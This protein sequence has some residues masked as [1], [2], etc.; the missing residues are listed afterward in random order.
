M[1]DYDVI[2]VG[3]G[4]AGLTAG[5]HLSRAG[6]RTLLLERELL[7]G[8]LKNVHRVDEGGPSGAQLASELAEAVA[9][10]GLRVEEAEATGIE[11]FSSTRWVAC[12]DGR[13]YS[14]AVVVVAAGSRCRRLGVPGEELLLGRGVIDCTPCD[15]G[16]F[17]DRA[18]A[19]CGSDD[20]ALA[21]ALYLADLP[22]RV[23][24][25]TRSAGLRADAALLRRA[26][27]HPRV[28]TRTGARLDAILGADRVEGVAFTDIATGRAETLDVDGVVIRVGTLPNTAFLQ[29]VVDLD[30][31]GRVVADAGTETSAPHV[32]AAGDIRGGSRPLVAAAVSDGTAAA[33]RAEQLLST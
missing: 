23:T 10:S 14:A 12:R 29:G 17:V 25:L 9:Q 26:L 18:V 31:D 6:H 22:A 32:L 30:P 7:G 5:L 15:G 27:A 13:G 3:G 16:F 2:I 21:D 11:V 4:P 8:N 24:V 19:V 20:Q 33:R 28:E 1:F